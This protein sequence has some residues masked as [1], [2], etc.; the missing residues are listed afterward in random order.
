MSASDPHVAICGATDIGAARANNQDTFVIADL[1]S[2]DLTNPCSRADIPLSKQGIL[3]LVCDGMGGAAAGDLAARIAAE[4]VKEQLVGAGRTVAEHPN[5]SLKSAVSGANGAILAEAKAHPETRGMGTTCTAAIVLPDRLSVAQVGDSRA[6]L[7]RDGRLHLLT[8][9]QT[10]AEQLVESGALRPEDVSTFPYRHVL[11]QA[12][13]TRSTIEPI[14]SEVRLR[15]GDRI[16]LCSDGLHGPVP[17]HEIAR[18]L[19]SSPDINR[20]THDL[21]QAALAAGG[22]DNVTVVVADCE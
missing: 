5:E 14:T 17:D 13:G 19:G 3:L 1:Q 8:R 4:A 18:I 9:D 11:I 21:I 7:L 6:Y 10:M 16:L 22:P 20:V 15:R 12:V 2:G